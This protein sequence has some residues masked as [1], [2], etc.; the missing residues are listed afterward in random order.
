MVYISI[1]YAKA[2]LE[3]VPAEHHEERTLTRKALPGSIGLG[4]D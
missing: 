2:G 4:P 1:A 3:S